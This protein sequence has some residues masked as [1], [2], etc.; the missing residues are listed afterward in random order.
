MIRKEPLYG[1]TLKELEEVVLDNGLPKF[2]AKQLC[3]WLYKKSVG[4][5]EEMS[6]ISS[7]GREALSQRYEVGLSAPKQVSVS[8][9]GTKK[10]LFEVGES[11]FIESAYIPASD[12]A[13]LCLSTQVGC[14]MGCKFCATAL[15]GLKRSLSAGEILN[16]IVSLPE[17]D[18]LTNLVL[19]GMGEPLDNLEEVIKALDIVTAAWGYGWS[20]SRVTLSTAGI[21]PKLRE[22]IERTKVNIAVSL[23]NPFPSERE[24]IMPIERAYPITEIIEELKRWDWSGQRRLSFEYILMSKMNNSPRHIKELCRL[25]NGLKCRI[26]IIKFHKIPSS[27][28]YSPPDEKIV[29][30]RDALTAKGIHTT[31]RTS[32]GE[33]IKAACGLLSTT[34]MVNG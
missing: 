8:C 10:Y 3:D 12:R 23:H 9:D 13:T 22:V 21:T 33:D 34:T 27:P 26:N 11:S 32:R 29:T 6:N 2:T 31:I 1:K 28:Y 19:M 16:Q 5:I 14:R 24:E 20:P 30:F 17:R 15:Q 7:K 18:T 4:S 25:L